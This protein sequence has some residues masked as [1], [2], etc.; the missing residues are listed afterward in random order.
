[1][2]DVHFYDLFSPLGTGL[3]MTIISIYFYFLFFKLYNY[4]KCN[5]ID[6]LK[7]LQINL[8]EDYSKTFFAFIFIIFLYGFGLLTEDMT[9]HLC[10]SE[11][12]HN[13]LINKVKKQGIIKE[14]GTLRLHTI[15]KDSVTLTEL[16]KEVFSNPKFY[17][18]STSLLK[19]TYFPE[20]I[21]VDSFW[22]MKGDSI[23]KKDTT[24]FIGFINGIYYT[25]KNWCYL[26]SK[27]I[28]DELDGIQ[29]RIDL[30]RSVAF[31][32]YFSI[33]IL[34]CM[35]TIY[36]LREIVRWKNQFK[37]F[38]GFKIFITTN[39]GSANQKTITIRKVLFPFKS[40]IILLIL[41]CS[42]RICYEASEYNF[43][44][45]ALGYY[46]SQAKLNKLFPTKRNGIEQNH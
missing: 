33:I 15:Y 42:S 41:F 10:D 16:G 24:N 18:D 14:E 38:N 44:E 30:A 20:R 4:K 1:M 21:N 12:S 11:K 36:Y 23:L 43:N 25:S 35:F 46:V 17:F 37:I 40:V 7:F 9:D 29:N 45:R 2:Y 27:Q 22:R 34:I 13:F 3:L 32:S 19:N 26:N 31:I 5:T 8:K 6:F 28:K 39:E